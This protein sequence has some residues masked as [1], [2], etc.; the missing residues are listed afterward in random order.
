[1]KRSTQRVYSPV[2]AAKY[3]PVLA[4]RV[5]D[6]LERQAVLDRLTDI[7][8]ATRVSDAP[9]STSAGWGVDIKI[10]APETGVSLGEVAKI[11]KDMLGHDTHIRGPHWADPLK[12]EGDVLA[13]KG[14]WT[15]AVAP[16]RPGARPTLLQEIERR[17]RICSGVGLTDLRV[18]VATRRA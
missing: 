12:G 14:Q 13:R 18:S 11:L 3:D 2:D 15:A 17:S 5:G 8:S 9:R 10:E 16:Y 6:Y 4:S 7:Q 1:M